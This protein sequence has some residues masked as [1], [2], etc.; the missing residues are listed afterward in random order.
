MI[1]RDPIYFAEPHLAP[2]NT[3]IN[4]TPPRDPFGSWNHDSWIGFMEY[5]ILRRTPLFTE[6]HLSQK[7]FPPNPWDSFYPTE[8]QRSLEK[9]SMHLY[10]T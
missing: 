6:T 7:I 2:L 5:H 10:P 4:R 8:P 9:Q 3:L 1:L